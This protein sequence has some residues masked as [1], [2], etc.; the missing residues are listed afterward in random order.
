M[1]V[2]EKS[3]EVHEGPGVPGL[4]PAHIIL[5]CFLVVLKDG[6]EGGAWGAPLI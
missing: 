2:L 6:G 5:C 3:L 1:L 4:V